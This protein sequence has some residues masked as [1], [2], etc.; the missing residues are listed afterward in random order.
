[1]A[2]NGIH[3]FLATLPPESH[4]LL[5]GGLFAG[6]LCPH[7]GYEVFLYAGLTFGLGMEGSTPSMD[8]VLR[9]V[10]VNLFISA[11]QKQKWYRGR[12]GAEA[13]K[14]RTLMF[15]SQR[16]DIVENILGSLIPEL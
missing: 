5:G 4:Q 7:Y 13:I 1:M 15:T 11:R 9:F 3:S 2:Q 6:T 8:A 14:G 12:F 10:V 16:F